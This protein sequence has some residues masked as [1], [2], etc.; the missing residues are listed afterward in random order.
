[1]KKINCFY[2]CFLLLVILI[3]NITSV[4]KKSSTYDEPGHLEFGRRV[5]M[6]TEINPSMQRM[7]VT[8]IN[9]LPLYP[10]DQLG[11]QLSERERLLIARIPTVLISLLLAFFIFFW[12]QR[13][14]G[15]KSGFFSLFL[16]AF[17]P[18]ILAH[19]RLITN[20][21]Y[22]AFFIITATFFFI[23]YIKEP[24]LKSL[25]ISALLT[26]IAQICKH[27]GLILLPLFLFLYLFHQWKDRFLI[28]IN[29]GATHKFPKKI[30]RHGLLFLLIVLFMINAGYLFKGTFDPKYNLPLPAAYIDSFLIGKKYNATGAGHGLVYL[31]GN[32][33]QHGF[34]YYY[35]VCLFLKL[36]LSIFIF[37]FFSLWICR[38]FVRENITE[39]LVLVMVPLAFFI[40]FSFFCSAQIGIRYLLPL[41]PFLY[42]WLGKLLAYSQQKLGTW[43]KRGIALFCL[44][45]LVS[46]LSF[47][48]HYLSYCNELIWDRKNI[49]KYLADS[50]VDWGQNAIYVNEYI[51]N[52]QGKE[53]IH[54]KPNGPVKGIVLV[55]I[56]H[57]VGIF[58]LTKE[59]FRWLREN[60][61]PV[62]HI[63]YSWLVYHVED[64]NI[65]Q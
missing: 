58:P 64:K 63:A 54:V 6:D 60:H 12:S 62:D 4:Y 55:N 28:K 53:P 44:W 56:N 21:I 9:Y 14:Y 38:K 48:P 51:K 29:A 35:V 1:M 24:C 15:L 46:S 47:F 17:S 50:N 22:S 26:G 16:Y 43:Y 36:P 61:E 45:Y 13:L 19:S 59:K 49:Y 30:I 8:L 23:R 18:N 5:I 57:L 42:V 40:F 37:S 3:L 33:S 32:L 10:A 11:I 2:L 27:T 25:V 34:W 20:D 52:Y 39:E 41:L 65:P 31:F 7:P